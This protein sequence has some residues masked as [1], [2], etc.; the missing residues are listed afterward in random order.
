LHR[1]TGASVQY[2][3]DQVRGYCTLRA[4]LSPVSEA[5]PTMRRRCLRRDVDGPIHLPTWQRSAPG[6]RAD[7]SRSRRPGST[8]ND[9][10][11]AMAGRPLTAFSGYRWTAKSQ[12]G[13]ERKAEGWP[14]TE[15]AATR[16]PQGNPGDP[17]KVPEGSQGEPSSRPG[18][19]CWGRRTTG[20]RVAHAAPAYPSQPFA[21]PWRRG[22]NG[23]CRMPSTNPTEPDDHNERT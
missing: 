6:R 12:S 4:T 23:A 18:R 2:A 8:V 20:P 22:K 10:P 19:A 15:I 11:P 1:L 17:S 3:P 21:A 7:G 5:V 16:V 9:E 13:V 14:R